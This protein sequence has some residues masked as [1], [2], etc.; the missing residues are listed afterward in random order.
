MK[1]TRENQAYIN[2][3]SGEEL[4]ARWRYR[5][6]GDQWFHGETAAYW[7][8]RIRALRSHAMPY[9]LASAQVGHRGTSFPDPPL[10]GSIWT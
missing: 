5:S 4:L 7:A 9:L 8:R 10:G 2:K 3:L 6:V 1:L